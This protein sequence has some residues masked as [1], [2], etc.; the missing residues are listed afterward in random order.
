[1]R[2]LLKQ[3]QPF[4]QAQGL[5]PVHR[6]RAGAEL[7]PLMVKDGRRV[8][9]EFKRADAPQMTAS[10]RIA[11]QDL[12]LEALYVVYPGERRYALAERVQAVPLSA[13]MPGA[14]NAATRTGSRDD[15][16]ARTGP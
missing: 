9:V 14:I 15:R 5:G 10:M 16:A 2:H 12:A 11:L 3:A 7:D 8:G 6:G 4:G 1:M 13:L